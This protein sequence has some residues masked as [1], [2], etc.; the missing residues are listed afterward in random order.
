VIL[1]AQPPGRDL[2]NI[3]KGW[4]FIKDTEK[5]STAKWEP[6]DLP[7]TWNVH[8]V[9]D[10][11]PGYYRGIGWYKKK[12]ETGTV[13]GDKQFFLYFEGANQ[14]TEVFI[15]GKKAGEHTGGYSGFYIPV[16]DLINRSGENELLVKVDNSHN[17]NIPPLSADFT[18]YGGIYRDAWLI[19]VDPVHFSFDAYGGNPVLINTPVVSNKS[20]TVVIRSGIT[21]HGS[22]DRNINIFS[23]IYNKSGKKIGSSS[24]QTVAGQGTDTGM[25][26]QAIEISD[27]FLWSPDSP[28]LYSV[29]TEI[30]DALSGQILDRITNPLGLRWF[31]FDAD[32]GFYLNGKH[33]HLTGTSRHQDYKGMGNAVPD[34]LAK[35][36]IELIKKMGGNFLRVAHYPQD[37]AV[38]A[39]CDSL[40]ILASVEIPIVN[41]ITETTAFYDNCIQMQQEMIRQQ[42]NHPSVIIW[43]YM[44]EVLLRTHY[45][46]DKEKQQVYFASVT[47]LARS[48]DSLTRKEDP[49]RYTMMAHHGDYDKYNNIG[50]VDIPMIVGWNLYSG[51]YGAN[52]YD[53]PVFLDSFHKKQ[54]MKPMVVSEFGADA[55]PRIRS[56]SPVRFDKS[57]EYTTAFHQYYFAEMMK[58]PY[59]A[60]AMIWNLAD[61]NSETRTETMPHI[62]NKGLLEWDRTPKDPYY[63]YKAMLSKDPFIKILGTQ[64]A[65]GIADSNNLFSMRTVQ[66]AT[67]LKTAELFFNNR[68]AG[69][70][71][72]KQGLCEWK[73]PFVNG[74]NDLKVV[75][76]NEGK[77]YVDKA[78]IPFYLLPGELKETEF[79]QMNILMGS[80]RYFR[81]K[82]QQ[83]WIPDQVY[84]QGGWGHVGGKTF[85]IPNNARLPYGTDKSIS[86]T[87]DDPIYQTQQVGINKYRIDAPAGEYDLTLYFAELLGGMVK[88]PPYNLSDPDRIEPNG[89]R[90][91]NVSVNGKLVLDNFDIS[92]QYGT[93]TAVTKTIRVVVSTDAGI[94]IDFESI[95]GEPVLNALQVKKVVNKQ[96]GTLLSTG[97]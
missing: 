58:R 85:V 84:K 92:A 54:P 33:L 7:H 5:N 65:A 40:G 9:M 75:A 73:L 78:T 24:F 29:T 76:G 62:N 27:P 19:A 53:F 35:K 14:F 97:D 79:R 91:F 96:P 22:S 61:F 74:T 1:L 10:D 43:C 16:T 23:V 12:L 30:K 81:D 4:E 56:L 38:L 82:D 77:S 36:D 26:R 68:S 94:G 51:W 90:I 45:R 88:E 21:N 25:I 60:G 69:K 87:D 32:K 59:V 15:N 39:A 20:A 71:Q 17:G 86:G 67:N 3:N 70:K 2:T 13:T 89:K 46:N 93:A 50:L 63:Y 83:M 48:L 11:I 52:L 28:Y 55:D 6:V 34:Q 18:F 41:E 66:V 64:P 44:N 57:V 72:P 49:E 80:R 95:E 31:H 37:P 47:K 42:Y 8:D